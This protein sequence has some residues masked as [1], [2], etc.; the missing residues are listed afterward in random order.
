MQVC[1]AI[2]GLNC[3]DVSA[4]ENSPARPRSS[5]ATKHRVICP[6]PALALGREFPPAA[7]PARRRCLAAMAFVDCVFGEC[8]TSG[9][10]RATWA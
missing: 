5:S 7:A 8:P 3:A 1:D 9:P 6:R 10:Y 4:R 2:Q